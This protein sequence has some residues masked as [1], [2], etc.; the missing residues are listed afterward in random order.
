M[1]SMTRT[2]LMLITAVLACGAA[3]AFGQPTKSFG[4]AITSA[5]I[6]DRQKSAI[7]QAVDKPVALAHEF[8]FMS[9]ET[10]MDKL[11]PFVAQL[12][13]E[14]DNQAITEKLTAADRPLLV[15]H[16][17][18]DKTKVLKMDLGFSV[19]GHATVKP[20]LK[21]TNLKFNKVAAVTHRGP[22]SQLSSVYQEISAHAGNKLAGETPQNTVILRLVTNPRAAKSPNDVVT[23]MIV[24]LK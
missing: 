4:Q 13:Q 9:I 7:R 14:L 6:D 16:G 20:P 11:D 1:T 2:S 5:P 24:P 22:P 12:M 3:I 19:P 10:S 8:V 23:E 15:V 21:A 17:N 18:P